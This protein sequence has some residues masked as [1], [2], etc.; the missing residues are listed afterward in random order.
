MRKYLLVFFCLFNLQNL[1]SA[2]DMQRVRSH[3]NTLC[4][5]AM[6]GRGYVNQGDKVAAT[7]I[8]NA[9]MQYNVESFRDGYFQYF[10]IDI[11]TFPGNVVLK[12][13]KQE[14]KPGIDYIVDPASGS[15]KGSG[16]L[17]LLDTAIFSDVQARD[18][19]LETRLNNKVLVYRSRDRVKLAALPEVVYF[20]MKEAKALIELQDGKL[21]A[22]LATEQISKPVFKVLEQSFDLT[23]KK[24]SYELDASLVKNYTT[25][26]VIGYIEGKVQP[27]SFV[28]ITAHYDH[29]GR[30]GEEVYFPGANDN[31]SGVSMMLELAAWYA[32]P[33]NRPDYSI[34][35][36]AFGA[37]EVG[38]VGSRYYTQNPFFPLS[39]ISFL[40][41]LDLLGTGD[42]G[43]MTVNA[44]V[45]PEAFALLEQVNQQGEYIQPLAKRGKA[46]NSDH[47]F[48]SESGVPAFFHYTL[49]G[50]TA[51][52][53]VHDIPETLPL[54]KY[55]QV[56]KL[57][58]DFIAA[59]QR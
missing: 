21:T 20:K 40:I 34:M 52:H 35:F 36:V 17:F 7:Y 57:L 56:Y 5:P 49:G 55:S 53:N 50:I 54:T 59:L 4:S 38:L 44:T 12:S 31:A 9:F 46:A 41:N 43:L 14:L 47:Y 23:A 10:N 2:Q 16:L 25:Q 48:F 18:R 45:F 26:N 22:S 32:L 11:N 28:A 27:D 24:V 19:F 15:G 30:M 42:D 6:H 29:L 51:Y 1:A 3:I 33:E 13:N 58:K 39:K 8:R 37:E